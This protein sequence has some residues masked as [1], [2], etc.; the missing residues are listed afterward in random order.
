MTIHSGIKSTD[1][2]TLLQQQLSLVYQ[3]LQ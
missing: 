3:Q 1:L 2:I